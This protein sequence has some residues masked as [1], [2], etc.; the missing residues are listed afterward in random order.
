MSILTKA[1]YEAKYTDNTTGLFADNTTQAISAGDLRTFADDNS[2]SFL[3]VGAADLIAVET[4]IANASIDT[5]NSAPIQLVAAPGVGFTIVPVSLSC[6]Y[7]YGT[8][9]FATNTEFGLYVGTRLVTT[10]NSTLLTQTADFVATIK[11]IDFEFSAASLDNQPLYF[12]ILTG[13]P[14][15]GGTS[16]LITKLMYYVTAYAL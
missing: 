16:Y 4:S 10:T 6:Y 11:A 12:K 7:T 8:A 14:T 2:D 13:D 9:A 15:G 1:A 3:F 5:A